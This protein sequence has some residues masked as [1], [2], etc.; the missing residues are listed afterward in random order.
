MGGLHESLAHQAGAADHAV[1]PRVVRHFDNRRN[2]AAFRADHDAVCILEFDFAARIRAVPQLVLEPLDQYRIL[3]AVRPPARHE[4]AGQAAFGAREDQ[5]RIAHRGGKEPF[6]SGQQ[7]LRTTPFAAQGTRNRC[8]GPHVGAAL[9]LGHAHADHHGCLLF[10]W[11]VAGIVF[12]RKQLGL[13]PGKQFRF[14]LQDRDGS[15]SHRSRAQGT[16]FHLRLHEI[17]GGARHMGTRLRLHPGQGMQSL[18]SQQGQQLMPARVEFDRIDAIAKTVM[19]V[20]LRQMAI[21]QL[22]QLQYFPAAEFGAETGQAFLMPA[23]AALAQA[24]RQRDISRKDVVAD[25]FRYLIGDFMSRPLHDGYPVW[26]S[27]RLALLPGQ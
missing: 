3:A 8:V 24:I 11:Q 16:G 19:R 22:P 5:M 15:E 1:K 20:Q 18:A 4:K 6:V 13:Q 21:G 7:I 17:A 12:T 2:P 14:V 10:Q 25:E 9:L 26:V 23:G 27:S